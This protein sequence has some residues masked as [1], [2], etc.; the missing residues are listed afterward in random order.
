MTAIEV[1]GL[2]KQYGEFK[3][4]NSIQFSIEENEIIGVIGRNGAGKSTLLKCLAGF[5]YPSSGEIRVLGENPFDNLFVSENLIFVDDQM[6]FS[7]E[8]T[9]EDIL[10]TAA[11][12]YPNWNQ[13]LAKRLFD[14]FS[15][16]PEQTHEMLSKGKRSTFNMIIGLCA[17]TKIT[18]FDEPTTGMDYS[19][20]KDFY[21]ALLKDYLQEPRTIILSS[22]LLNELET[23]LESILLIDDGRFVIQE[24][25]DQLKET[26]Y[27]LTG[28]VD[29][30]RVTDELQVL[31]EEK[32]TGDQVYRVV[33]G[34]LSAEKLDELERNHVQFSS[35]SIDDI[36][37]YH[38]NAKRG[39]IDH[40]FES[41]N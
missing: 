12:F 6:S 17:R 27:G 37:V 32:L 39:G 19:V 1:N 22:H 33:K 38:T 4:L 29:H 25:I 21:R 31:H 35:V 26:T 40:V 16:R 7:A 14:Y 18:I 34:E 8:L 23:V 2:T 30:L 20:R 9:L 41:E 3:A 5:Y 11:Q 24:S 13:A 36:C 28:S 10:H 15:F